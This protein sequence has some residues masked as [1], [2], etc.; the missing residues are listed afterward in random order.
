MG[1][2]PPHDIEEALKG[3]S[4]PSWLQPHLLDSLGNW[5][6]MLKY[7]RRFA[8]A[9]DSSEMAAENLALLS[10]AGVPIVLGSMSGMPCLPHGPALD[11]ELGRL[12][13]PRLAPRPAIPAATLHSA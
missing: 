5:P 3:V 7:S 4:D 6:A 10:G 1:F 2:Q 11:V 8:L 13:D 12:V 9:Q